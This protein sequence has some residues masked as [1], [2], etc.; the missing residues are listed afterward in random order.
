MLVKIN[1]EIKQFADVIEQAEMVG[2]RWVAFNDW[3]DIELLPS[4]LHFFGSTWEAKQFCD[5]MN[6]PD[7]FTEQLF[8]FN[9]YRYTQISFLKIDLGLDQ[10]PNGGTLQLE[11]EG[12]PQLRTGVT[13][14]AA[15]YQ[16]DTELNVKAYSWQDSAVLSKYINNFQLTLK[17]TVVMNQKNLEFLS[18]QLRYNGFGEKLAEEMKQK[19]EQQ[20]EKF[21]L[22]HQAEFNGHK[23]DAILDFNKSKESEMYFFNNY[24]VTL[25]PENAKAALT[26]NFYIQHKGQSV[27][28][29][30]AYNL[31][32]GRAVF[33]EKYA[34][35]EGQTYPAWL[36]L[37]F[38]ELDKYGSFKL[39]PYNEN[40][41]FK[42]EEAISKHPIMEMVSAADK[43]RLVQ[44]LEKGNRVEVTFNLDGKLEKRFV[45]ACPTSHGLNLFDADQKVIRQEWEARPQQKEG[46]AAKAGQAAEQNET[47]K[48]KNN[49][50]QGQQQ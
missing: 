31:M 39:H 41:G 38:K 37:N 45:E 43:A 23:V 20:P 44:S 50:K 9:N 32:N 1:T 14:F 4:G 15:Y 11:K 28:L 10:I 21:Q 26:Q 8:N 6:G 42:L 30:E 5:R 2:K 17:N 19:I 36:K 18:D 29:K 25:L 49:K 40:Y 12:F 46:Q 24:K 48:K 7:D 33:K 16:W 47:N 27:N 3:L 35:K 22:R 34:N 13:R